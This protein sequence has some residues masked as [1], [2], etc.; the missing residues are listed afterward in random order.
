MPE[1]TSNINVNPSP[2]QRFVA[3]KAYVDAHRELIQ[4]PDM[5]RAFD[6]ALAHMVWEQT[7]V[8]MT[9][10]N[11]AAASYYRLAGAQRLAA[12]MKE[13]AESPIVAPRKPSD[14]EMPI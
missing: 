8:P 4:R 10:G 12:L 2:R 14:K 13:L 11:G 6:F 7:S 5:Q 1:L 9:D 3:V